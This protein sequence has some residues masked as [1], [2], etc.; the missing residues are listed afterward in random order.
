MENIDLIWS[1]IFVISFFALLVINKKI[2]RNNKINVLTITFLLILQILLWAIFSAYLIYFFNNQL[3]QIKLLLPINISLFLLF[4][5]IPFEWRNLQKNNQKLTQIFKSYVGQSVL[6]EILKTNDDFLQANYADVSVLIVDIV[7]F[8]KTVEALNLQKSAKLIKSILELLTK[9]VIA[10]NGTLDKYNGDGLIAFWGAPLEDKNHAEN[11][12]LAAIKMFDF[13][14][15][16]NQKYNLNIN[17]R[18]GI[19]SGKVLVG[20]LGTDFRSSYTILGNCIN[21]ASRLEN[22]AHSYK[23]LQNFP[24]KILIG[25]NT[26]KILQNLA[27]KNNLLHIGK[28]KLR[29]SQNDLDIYTLK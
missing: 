2:K 19:E 16:F 22:I 14:D 9:A 29:G 24:R 23:N 13:L 17:I 15:Q 4:F 27:I 18:I 3:N 26:Q 1:L 12:I 11:C 21:Y 8:T 6:D 25:E 10:T 20:D 28:I 5:V 7:G